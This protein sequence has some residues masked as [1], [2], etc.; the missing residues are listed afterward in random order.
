MTK[1]VVVESVEERKNRIKEYLQGVDPAVRF[2]AESGMGL[3]RL[4]S[5]EVLLPPRAPKLRRFY[6]KQYNNSSHANSQ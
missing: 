3:K 5:E 2:V 6:S 4:F 1:K